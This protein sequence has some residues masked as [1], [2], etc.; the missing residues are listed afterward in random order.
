MPTISYYWQHKCKLLE[1]GIADIMPRVRFQT[2]SRYFHVCDKPNEPACNSPQYD[3]LYKIRSFSDLLACKHQPLFNIGS[4]VT[5]DEAM[6]PYKGNIGFKQY[7]KDKPKKWGIK[8]WSLSNART[9]YVYR[10]LLYT[11]KSIDSATE[12]GSLG[13]RVVCGL[14]REFVGQGH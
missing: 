2:I 6:V 14:L 11:G 1:T 7:M 12:Q 8:V 5:I 4:E 13:N 9:G 10:Q 3:K